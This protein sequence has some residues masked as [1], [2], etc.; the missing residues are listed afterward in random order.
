MDT[1]QYKNFANRWIQEPWKSW[2]RRL[3]SFIRFDSVYGQRIIYAGLLTHC[4]AIV[5]SCGV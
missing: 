2:I 1:G 3:F 5:Y 4:W